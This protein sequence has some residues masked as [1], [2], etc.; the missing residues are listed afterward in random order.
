MFKSKIKKSILFLGYDN[1]QTRLINELLKKDCNVSVS[2][3]KIK[4]LDNYD[5]VISFGYRHLIRKEILDNTK[6]PIINLHIS[7]LP[8]NRGAHPNFWA[9]FDS[10]PA[11]VSIHLVDEGIDT[12]PIIAQKLIKFD[13]ENFNFKETYLILINEVEK[14]FLENLDQIINETFEVFT[15]KNKGTYHRKS[16]LP[17]SFLG[18]DE[19]INKEITRLHKLTD[20]K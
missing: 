16:D 10:T 9:F 19:N 1:T 7:Y 2:S 5:L 14:L 8:W 3:G 15:Q 4:S 12:G 18:W 6:I 17:K 11:G 20:V 13:T